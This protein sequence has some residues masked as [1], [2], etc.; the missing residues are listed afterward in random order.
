MRSRSCCGRRESMWESRW[1]WP[2]N[3]RDWFD[4]LE[5]QTPP[6]GRSNKQQRR[7]EGRQGTQKQGVLTENLWPK[8]FSEAPRCA[9]LRLA[10]LKQAEGHP[11]SVEN[12]KMA[13]GCVCRNCQRRGKIYSG[14]NEARTGPPALLKSE[15]SGG[16]G[17][18]SSGRVS[19]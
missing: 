10:W 14:P 7:G 8:L 17:R 9:P 19:T 18:S 13:N 3:A 12:T 16:C 5:P 4:T 11:Q 2:E 6:T 1:L 15:G